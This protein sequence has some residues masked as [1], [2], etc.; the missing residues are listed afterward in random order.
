[1]SLDVMTCQMGS[2][3]WSIDASIVCGEIMR[4]VEQLSHLGGNS[5][6]GD[7]RTQRGHALAAQV[8]CWARE[9]EQEG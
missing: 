1:V 6:G 7:M 8:R 4:K 5:D 9:A 3:L 2:G